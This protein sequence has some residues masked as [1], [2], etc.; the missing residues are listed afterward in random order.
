VEEADCAEEMGRVRRESGVVIDPHSAVGVRAAR[1]ALAAAPAT[2]VIAL[3]TAHPA[4]FP[5]A[6]ERAAGVRPPLPEPLSDLMDRKEAIVVLPNDRRAVA[7]AM[8]QTVRA[9]A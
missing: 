7:D 5:D 6:V 9:P 8:R 2:P 3:G 4:K 1:K